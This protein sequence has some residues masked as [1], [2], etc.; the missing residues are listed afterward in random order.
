[1][2]ASTADHGKH[3]QKYGD[4]TTAGACHGSDSDN[5]KGKSRAD[6]YAGVVA[7]RVLYRPTSRCRGGGNPRRAAAGNGKPPS[8]L[9]KMSGAAEAT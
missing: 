2:E 1:M 4:Q 6:L 3:K 9:S 8:R 7:Q 5:D